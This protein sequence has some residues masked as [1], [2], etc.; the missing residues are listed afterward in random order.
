[1]VCEK[2]VAEGVAQADALFPSFMALRAHERARH[3]LLCVAY[4]AVICIQCPFCRSILSSRE[5]AQH[6]VDRALR[7]GRCIVDHAYVAHALRPPRILQCALCAIAGAPT[8]EAHTL[9]ALQDQIAS[10]FAHPPA[11]QLDLRDGAATSSG[12]FDRIQDNWRRRRAVAQDQAAG[13]H[14]AGGRERSLRAR[15][16]AAD[17]AA[18]AAAAGA[19]ADIEPASL[20][21]GRFAGAGGGPEP[22]SVAGARSTGLGAA[23]PH[24]AEPVRQ[25]A[26]RGGGRGSAPPVRAIALAAA[27]RASSAGADQ[28]RFDRAAAG[29]AGGA[30]GGASPGPGSRAGVDVAERAAPPAPSGGAKGKSKGQRGGGGKAALK[31]QP[32]GGGR[33]RPGGQ[34]SAGGSDL[35]PVAKLALTWRRRTSS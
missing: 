1:M 15:S 9:A 16:V 14:S 10:H 28:G 19:G 2:C 18:G 26:S 6:H 5:C 3:G 13:G 8:F 21:G 25:G 20:A 24:G 34:A 35:L 7:Q 22:A 12:L 4:Q 33:P 30:G 27:G 31:G 32:G 29:V 23:R 11:L 17:S